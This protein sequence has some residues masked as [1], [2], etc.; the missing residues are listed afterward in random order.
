MSTILVSSL[1]Y[2]IK[3]L[4]GQVEQ[5][6]KSVTQLVQTQKTIQ[7]SVT[8]IVIDAYPRICMLMKNKTEPRLGYEY[9]P[10]GC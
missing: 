6:V 3:E 7:E 2:A 9:F 10:N 1:T 5:C 4:S 8:P